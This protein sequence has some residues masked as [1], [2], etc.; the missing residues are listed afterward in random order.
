MKGLFASLLAV[1]LLAPAALA[2]GTARPDAAALYAKYCA[3]CHGKGRLGGVGPAL[4]PGN[5]R[6]L[7]KKRAAKV[8]ATL[9]P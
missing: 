2:Q 5:L 7:H 6:R 8:I 9:A 1:S 3:E 4:L